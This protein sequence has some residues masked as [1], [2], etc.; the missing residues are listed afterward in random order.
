M[1]KQ[2]TAISVITA[3]SDDLYNYLKLH[4]YYDILDFLNSIEKYISTNVVDESNN[5]N[6]FIL[7]ILPFLKNLNNDTDLNHF[8][9]I[10]NYILF[11]ILHSLNSNLLTTDN[12]TN[13]ITKYKQYTQSKNNNITSCQKSFII[14]H[15]DFTQKDSTNSIIFTI[16]ECIY[17]QLEEEKKAIKKIN[18]STSASS[19]SAS[20]SSPSPSSSSTSASSASSSSTSASSALEADLITFTTMISKYD[21]LIFSDKIHSYILLLSIFQH[22]I[23]NFD[24]DIYLDQNDSPC[25]IIVYSINNFIKLLI[26]PKLNMLCYMYLNS[27]ASSYDLLLYLTKSNKTFDYKYNISMI[28]NYIHIII[29][30]HIKNYCAKKI[31]Q[32]T[33]R[34]NNNIIIED[35]SIIIKNLS[36]Q[37][38]LAAQLVAP[39]PR[40]K[41]SNF[42]ISYK[43]NIMTYIA[44]VAHTAIAVEKA[45]E[46]IPKTIPENVPSYNLIYD[47]TVYITSIVSIHG[48]NNENTAIIIS[49]YYNYYNDL[50]KLTNVIIETI[51][52]H[53]LQKIIIEFVNDMHMW[54][55]DRKYII[56]AALV[57]LLNGHDKATAATAAAIAANLYAD[58]KLDD[59]D[60][61]S[62][63]DNI[64]TVF[65]MMITNFFNKTYI[66]DNYVKYAYN[67]VSCYNVEEDF[68]V[69]V[70]A[71]ITAVAAAIKATKI[72]AAADSDAAD[73]DAA[74]S[75][76]AAA[77]AL[78]AGD[79][80]NKCNNY[81]RKVVLN[82]ILNTSP[83]NDTLKQLTTVYITTIATI[84]TGV[85]I[86]LKT[87]DIYIISKS[88]SVAN[89][90]RDA[91]DDI[92]ANGV[93]ATGA[94]YY[95]DIVL[96]NIDSANT[97]ANKINNILTYKA[98]GN[99][100]DI[101]AMN[102]NTY[103][104]IVAN[105][106]N[107]ANAANAV[108]AVIIIVIYL[109]TEHII[110][111][112]SITRIINNE[113]SH[114]FYWFISTILNTYTNIAQYA[115]D[116]YKTKYP[117][118]ADNA[119]NAD[120]VIN[121]AIGINIRMLNFYDKIALPNEY[122]IKQYDDAINSAVRNAAIAAIIS[123]NTDLL[124][125]K[126]YTSEESE[127]SEVV[128]ANNVEPLTK[129][130]VDA[131]TQI[132]SD[133]DESNKPTNFIKQFIKNCNLQDTTLST[134]IATTLEAQLKLY[135]PC[136]SL[137]ECDFNG[138]SLTTFTNYQKRLYNIDNIKISFKR[139]VN[140]INSLI[141]TYK[142]S[143][144]VA[145]NILQDIKRIIKKFLVTANNTVLEDDT[146]LQSQPPPPPPP[147]Q[148]NI[149]PDDINLYKCIF[150]PLDE[151]EHILVNIIT[152]FMTSDQ[153]YL[154]LYVYLEH[155][156]NSFTNANNFIKSDTNKKT[157]LQTI[158]KCCKKIIKEIFLTSYMKKDDPYVIACLQCYLYTKTKI[159]AD[160][161][162][163][164]NNEYYDN[165]M[166]LIMRLLTN[167]TSYFIP[168]NL[169]EDNNVKNNSIFNNKTTSASSINDIFI[170]LSNK[171][172]LEYNTTGRIAALKSNDY[173]KR[174][175]KHQKYFNGGG[176]SNNNN[177]NPLFENPTVML[178]DTIMDLKKLDELY[179]R[180]KTF[181]EMKT[182]A[183][184]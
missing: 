181:S 33:Y 93:A 127:E 81:T 8:E 68:I 151:N 157:N 59:I 10:N 134:G 176:N 139:S 120:N 167:T 83:N 111:I 20:A 26:K 85:I 36:L 64:E 149:S 142:Y 100:I 119:D 94:N 7:C 67:A 158:I 15:N 6:K 76:A 42:P 110:S 27:F 124:L 113:K 121:G 72:S 135:I 97:L 48:T 153:P 66:N 138:T 5:L 19:P 65:N 141:P 128:G 162:K 70:I 92:D 73:S 50:S 71:G 52:E 171:Y 143:P 104:I 58:F 106:N 60:D 144:P 78:V 147:P 1:T 165:I 88:P 148:S 155:M 17:L 172:T 156:M 123:N 74:A 132:S 152:Y 137:K 32:I 31:K 12:I 29:S 54:C 168:S 180:I 18:A 163:F 117:A 23:L 150:P 130:Y 41:Y 30:T 84:L 89:A 75:A 90:V 21:N 115:I 49:A 101:V 44:H 28:I 53:P 16:L 51:T 45:V 62:T 160:N 69:S 14:T 77:A 43:V 174:D 2:A 114:N 159:T 105:V 38:Q 173:K 161:C 103:A 91:N 9:S 169:E 3:Q 182:I 140:N 145:A 170:S 133:K 56:I 95:T 82:Y 131:T 47:K 55:T 116:N 63:K 164:T 39:Q 86:N 24:L 35:A 107:A 25:D 40:I 37:S 179:E 61:S 79:F 80:A 108:I 125:N 178:F 126:H 98:Y 4:I 13:I 154:D 102:A 175:S 96:K 166:H 122:S 57:A 146:I 99:A 109:I 112:T 46:T 11:N 136:I 183:L 87:S 184:F 22:I 34:S 118:N 129:I 177:N